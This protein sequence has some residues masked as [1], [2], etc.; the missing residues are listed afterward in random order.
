MH[1]HLH[2]EL[3][4]KNQGWIAMDFFPYTPDFPYPLATTAEQEFRI[5]QMELSTQPNT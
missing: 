4:S 3:Q 5:H 2:S 1:L